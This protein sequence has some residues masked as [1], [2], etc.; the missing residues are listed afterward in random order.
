MSRRFVLS[1]IWAIASGVMSSALYASE[2]PC[3]TLVAVQY[4][5]AQ[6]D[7]VVYF[8][9]QRQHELSAALLERLALETQ[10]TFKVDPAQGQQAL[11][12]AQ[13][14]RVDLVVGVS[15]SPA[16][17]EQLQYLTPA[18]AQKSYR[19][20]RR[21]HEQLSLSRWPELSG[22][23][24]VMAVPDEHLVEF[25]QQAKQLN[26]PLKT[27]GSVASAVHLLLAGDADYLLAE[28]QP[29]QEHI[30]DQEL[31]N[32]FE[33]IEPAVETVQLFVAISHDSV[34]NTVELRK[35]LSAALKQFNK[36]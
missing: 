20:W 18:Y 15:N 34:C 31:G 22:L 32:E 17:L 16:Q 9:S 28:E 23:R 24:G 19:I 10:L 4:L 36:Q 6:P 5:N 2:Q 7:T 25:K 8:D 12:E 35:T 27:V 13:S 21:S 1:A 26:W 33:F 29:L 11:R 30:S 14:G 3:E